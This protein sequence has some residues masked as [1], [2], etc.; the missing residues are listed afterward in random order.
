VS[1]ELF[2]SA[3]DAQPMY[4]QIVEQVTIKVLSGDWPAGTALPSIREMAA[5]NG[6]SVITVKRAYLELEHAGVIITRHG[7]GSFVADSTDAPRAQQQAELILH[8]DQAL[9]SA[10]RLGLS[11]AEFHDLIQTRRA[12]RATD[13]ASS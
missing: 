13:G 11:D 6:V 2:L 7:K 12:Q 10:E 9:A 1:A 3:S 5:A 4:R 8:L